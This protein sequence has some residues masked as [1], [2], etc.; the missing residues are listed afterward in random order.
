MINFQVNGREYRIRDCMT[1]GAWK[2][3]RATVEEQ[4]YVLLYEN[5]VDAD[6]DAYTDMDAMLD[7]VAFGDVEGIREKIWTVNG[8]A[9]DPKDVDGESP[10][11]ETSASDTD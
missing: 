10:L 9:D 5:L 7:T 3:I 2:R 1:L 11:A 8:V 6:G 4:G